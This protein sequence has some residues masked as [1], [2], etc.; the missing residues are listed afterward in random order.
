MWLTGRGGSGKEFTTIIDDTGLDEPRPVSRIAW[1]YD[2]RGNF[3]G[4]KVS[5][6]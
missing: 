4:A 1:Q 6:L 3:V 5:G 2:L